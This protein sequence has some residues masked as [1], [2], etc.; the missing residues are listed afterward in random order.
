MTLAYVEVI[1]HIYE[2]TGLGSDFRWVA[3][4]GL[5]SDHAE[6]IIRIRSAGG[7]WKSSG[8]TG[9]ARRRRA[10]EPGDGE[11][12][13]VFASKAGADIDPGF[14]GYEDETDRT[15]PVVLEAR[16]A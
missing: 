10:G 15:I 8:H 9:R 1:L 12:Y 14:Q 3:A 11:A 5:T 13:A 4:G 6:K 16:D 7:R 2:S